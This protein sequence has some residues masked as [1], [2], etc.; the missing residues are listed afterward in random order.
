MLLLYCVGE[1]ASVSQS[2]PSGQ[3][4]WSC[5]SPYTFCGFQGAPQSHQVVGECLYP[6]SHVLALVF[7]FFNFENKGCFVTFHCSCFGVCPSQRSCAWSYIPAVY[8]SKCFILLV[9]TP[10]IE[11]RYWHFHAHF[12]INLSFNFSQ[13]VIFA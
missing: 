4:L 9:L 12:P 3:S 8:A 2:K 11:W 6:L 7:F 13:F 1:V 10:E 5:F